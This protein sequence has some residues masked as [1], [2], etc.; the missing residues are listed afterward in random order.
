MLGPH[1]GGGT[2]TILERS[3]LVAVSLYVASSVYISQIGID[4]LQS[5]YKS[6]L[7]FL[8]TAMEAIGRQHLITKAFLKQAILDIQT[9]GL[10]GI[11]RLPKIASDS[12]TDGLDVTCGS[13]IPLFARSKVSRHTEILPPLP[14]RLPLGA[15]IGHKHWDTQVPSRHVHMIPLGDVTEAVTGENANKR[16]RVGSPSPPPAG[17]QVHNDPALWMQAGA[18]AEEVISP[19]T[20][21]H[22]PSSQPRPNAPNGP[23]QDRSAGL[24]KLPHRA[25][26]SNA[27]SPSASKATPSV[28]TPGMG[29]GEAMAGGANLFGSQAADLNNMFNGMDPWD[30]AGMYVQVADAIRNGNFDAVALET[31]PWTLLNQ[32]GVGGAWDTGGGGGGGAG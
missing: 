13:N 32:G 25:G 21:T 19:D 28:S 17:T 20:T 23:G 22:Q 6:N 27:S 8:I 9:N 5:T 16:K 14:G 15:P 12:D 11:V 3:P 24:L 31:D 1:P 10:M 29:G 30:A 26:S 4:G 18:V 2:L 7:E